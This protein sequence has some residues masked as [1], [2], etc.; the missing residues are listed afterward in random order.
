MTANTCNRGTLSL[1]T[2]KSM[3]IAHLVDSLSCGGAEKVVTSLALHQSQ[4]HVVRVV[5]LRGLGVQSVDSG[6]LANAGV[7]IVTLNKPGGF[8]PETL[9]RLAAYLRENQIEVIHTHNHLVHHYGAFAGRLAGCGAVVNTLHGIATLR[10]PWWARILF[11]TSCL[12]GDHVVSVSR[13][14]FDVFRRTYPLPRRML[15][16]VENG[17][18]FSAG[19]VIGRRLPSDVITFGNI[20][21]F[22]PVKDH[23][24]LLRA[25]AIVRRKHPYTRLRLLGD[26]VMLREMMDLATSMSLADSVSFDG[27]SLDTRSFLN[28]IDVYVLSSKSEGLPLTLLE[29]MAAGRPVVA[30]A[31]G[32]V[33]EI[34]AKAEC[35]WLCPPSNPDLLASA[36]ERALVEP[37]LSE[38]G[39]RGRDAVERHYTVERMALD[40]E[41]IY[42][43]ILSGD[44]ATGGPNVPSQSVRNRGK[45]LF[46]L[47]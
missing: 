12:V 14:V 26:G 33:P 37:A 42:R 1:W 25:F 34:I 31:V 6:E 30:T 5:C 18:E 28:G 16:I 46:S 11:L 41:Q 27:F 44:K 29:A 3:R 13:P 45:M 8:H 2:G 19:F 47:C 39:A 40:Y 35:G 24:N 4:Q 15:S 36:M 20:A 38:I 10:M 17:I 32:G 22:D 21:R 9:K 23:R 7:Q 43:R